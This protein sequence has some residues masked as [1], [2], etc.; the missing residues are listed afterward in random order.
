MRNS[1]RYRI[2][3]VDIRTRRFGYCLIELPKEIL[4]FGVAT[5]ISPIEASSRLFSLCETFHPALIVYRKESVRRGRAYPRTGK[6]RRSLLNE[7]VRL[8]IPVASVS[9]QTLTECFRQHGRTTKHGIA[10]LL[11]TWFPRLASKLPRRRRPW[12]Q[13]PW[14]LTM[15]DAAALGI[16]HIA[17]KAEK[18][19]TSD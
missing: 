7:A 16:A 2:L 11:A 14:N 12:D 3:A 13:E 6:I 1:R 4:D 18:P 5:F 8:G 17:L 15:F 9:Q 19:P 10:S